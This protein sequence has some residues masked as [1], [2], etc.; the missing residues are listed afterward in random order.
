MADSTLSTLANIR[1]KIRRLSRNPS[2]QQLTDSEIDNYIN[3]FILYDFPASIR[4]NILKQVFTFY[5]TPNVEKYTTNTV[6]ATDPMYNFKNKYMTVNPPIYIGGIKAGFTQSRNTFYDIYPLTNYKEEIGTGDGI[7][8]NFTGIVTNVPLLQNNVTVNSIDTGGDRLLL[9]DDGNGALVGDDGAAS[10]IAYLG[11]NYD[12]TFTFPPAVGETVWIQYI[13]YIASKPVSVLYFQNEF[14][15]RPV[16]D[17]TYRVD[18]SVD[19][20]PTELS[21]VTDMPELAQ[22]HEYISYGAAIKVLQDRLD[23]ETVALLMP[24]FKRQEMLI[25]TKKILQ[26]SKRRS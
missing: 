15:L 17:S 25:M 10:S 2:T 7:E 6:D 11:G 16:P 5:T 4:S 13:P 21:T 20:R 24:E 26:N 8:T 22:W 12:I 1:T 19:V 9:T 3:N 14:I 23:M 18:V